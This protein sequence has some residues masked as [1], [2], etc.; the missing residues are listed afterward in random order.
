MIYELVR[1]EIA[2]C[3]LRDFTEWPLHFDICTTRYIKSGSKCSLV[4]L[5][6]L[7]RC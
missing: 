1:S 6:G 3:E 4:A 2:Q 7:I 5:G